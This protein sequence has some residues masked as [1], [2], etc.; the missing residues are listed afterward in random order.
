[1]TLLLQRVLFSLAT[2]VWGVCCV[3]FYASARIVSYLAEDFRI[4]CLVGGLA[5]CVLGLFTLITAKDPVADCGHDHDHVHDHEESDLH[6]IFALLTMVLPILLCASF[7]K[8]SFSEQALK[9]KAENQG[10]LKAET[11]FSSALPPY[12]L[13]Y[14]EKT[15]T[16]TDEGY[17]KMPLLELYFANSDEEMR[18][19]LTGQDVQVEGRVMTLPDDRRRMTLYRLFVTC[20]AA[21]SRPIPLELQLPDRGP[22]LAVKDWVTATGNLTFAEIDGRLQ[23]LLEVDSLEETAPPYEELLQRR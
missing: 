2:I 19:V 22:E 13:E 8:D 18:N 20:C 4:Y 1:M 15:R 3:Y 5:L 17:L 16:R 21:D 7:T 10:E 23:G 9:R 14:L 12:T 11:F 6:P